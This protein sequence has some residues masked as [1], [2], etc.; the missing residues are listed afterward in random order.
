MKKYSKKLKKI[1]LVFNFLYF[2]IS[3]FF[4]FLKNKMG[5]RIIPTQEIP[6][7]NFHEFVHSIPSLV[8]NIWMPIN[9][10]AV[11]TGMKNPKR[12]KNIVAFM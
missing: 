9:I 8:K 5:K 4:K 6:Q 2:S 11:K 10:M 7:N 3:L 1:K 12:Q